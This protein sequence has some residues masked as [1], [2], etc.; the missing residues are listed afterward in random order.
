[1]LLLAG[2]LDLSG[3]NR[4]FW[5]PTTPP[6]IPR[7]SQAI[8]PEAARLI[9]IDMEALQAELSDAP[10]EGAAAGLIFTLPTPEGGTERFRVVQSPVMAPGLA[11]QFPGIRTFLGRGIEE[12]SALARIDYTQKGF[13]A[14]VLK[15]PQTYFIDPYYHNY[16]HEAHQ[17][18]YRSDLARG[19]EFTC[20]ADHTSSA[21]IAPRSGSMIV[22]EELRTYRL[23]VAATGE[24][25]QFHGG[26]VADAMAA[27]VTT[28]NRVNGIYET[29][30]S[31]RM[32]LI[33]S[34]QQIIYTNPS[35]DPYNGG[36]G[37]H[38]GQNQV[39]LD[40]TI[41]NSSYDIGHVFHR[42]NGGGVA[43]YQALCDD[44]TKAGGFT[45]R[46][47]PV[48][49]PF[50]V[51]Y[52]AHEIGHQF[53]ASHTQNNNCNRVQE[54]AMEPGS[55]ST[56]M[57][58]AGICAPNLQDSSDPYF[59]AISQQEMFEHTIFGGGNTC[60]TIIST[61]NT[62]PVITP[63][64]SGFFIPVSTPFELTGTA[65][66]VD[67]DSL[68]YCWEQFD[69]GP[70]SPPNNP[71]GNAPIFRSFTP[72]TDSTRVFPRLQDLV[73]NTT[74]FGERLPDYARGLTFR[75]TVRDN[76]GFGGGVSTEDRSF[77]VTEQAGPF[78]VLSRNVVSSVV[79]EAGSLQL[80]EWDVANTDQPPVNASE[81]NI[82]LSVDGGLTYPYLLDEG[83][84]NDGADI[85]QLP[86]DVNSTDCR[87]KV[88]AANNIFFDINSANFS[89]LPPAA[90]GIAI[91]SET[92]V[93]P[94]CAEDEVTYEVEA[95]PLLGATGP[96][97]WTVEG[98]PAAFSVEGLE[99]VSLPATI[100]FQV[101]TTEGV[102][103][104]NY[105]FQLIGSNGPASDTLGLVLQYFAGLPEAVTPQAP[106]DGAIDV[107]VTPTLSWNAHP[108]AAAYDLEI[109]A[110][111]AF[112]DILFEES[113]IVDTFLTLASPLPD[114]AAIFWRVRG[115]NE[116]CGAGPYGISGFQTEVVRCVVY[117]AQ[118]MP[119]DLGQPGPF[120]FSAIDVDLDA[121][122]R[123]VNLPSLRGTYL[124]ISEID[125]RLRSP[126][127]GIIDLFS[128]SS[129]DNGFLINVSLDEQ[130]NNPVN[131]PPVGGPF[132][133]EDP[134]SQFN[135]SSAQGTWELVIFKSGNEGALAGWSIE[136]CYGL[137]TLSSTEA[138]PERQTLAIFPN[139]AS[140]PVTVQLPGGLSKGAVL[141]VYASTGQ[142]LE[143]VAVPVGQQQ[144]VLGAE[145]WPNGMYALRLRGAGGKTLGIGKFV[146]QGG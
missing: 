71:E 96:I 122:I 42:T 123:D 57:G 11:R 72:T 137:P 39:N 134:L 83:T 144:L 146:R 28:M 54:T 110:D 67:G 115:K 7:A 139:P 61:D 21:G 145:R 30:V 108:D 104:G 3:Q 19:E 9:A 43:F 6:D 14:M 32:I 138:S 113:G 37:D 74:V 107:A 86:A 12:G 20:A 53:G 136:I 25:T 125:F 44:G 140:G 126:N 33:D 62:P 65:T 58:Y 114:S 66:D 36:P 23:A 118:G 27:I 80:V 98:L 2:L 38:L 102:A 75:L 112:S 8:Q 103:S 97:Q 132:L 51:D 70:S 60:A 81:V 1:M 35:S 99:P 73:N 5:K 24:Y 41:G 18:Y 50:D 84:P 109:A 59:H 48:G 130:A 127:A 47:T 89:V 93:Q 69:T 63:G 77:D 82:Y 29:D 95:V 120:V 40:T 78:R 135:G 116:S 52:V 13:H 90:A 133:T 119:I 100:A 45:S 16:P 105:P 91:A 46:T 10:D 88:K 121:T 49:D 131:C 143:S 87:V 76:H 68:T 101:A 17:V 55:A 117:E 79:W 128:N 141:E 15:G 56:I 106:T 22:G 31:A 92:V 129:C 34:N 124:P 111:A 142:R 26:T 64:E 85:V 94:A 4:L